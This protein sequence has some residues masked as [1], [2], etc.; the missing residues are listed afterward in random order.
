MIICFVSESKGFFSSVQIKWKWCAW[1]LTYIVSMQRRALQQ[2]NGHT[3]KKQV[4]KKNTR[5]LRA[6]LSRS[7][8]DLVE[9]MYV[10]VACV[11]VW[12][13][14]WQE[15]IKVCSGSSVS[16]ICPAVPQ[17]P[18]G[19]CQHPAARH[20]MHYEAKFI[21]LFLF[22]FNSASATCA[23]VNWQTCQWLISPGV[24]PP[25]L[26]LAL[27]SP[28]L[29]SVSSL[30]LIRG[31]GGNRSWGKKKNEKERRIVVKKCM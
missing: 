19:L 4:H 27:A 14:E 10:N 1:C 9:F 8:A 24:R 17:G 26:V 18:G 22:P 7:E 13:S 28:Y 15:V 20:M 2:K 31:N 25:H 30:S 3:Q 29:A 11:S 23:F 6:L 5:L 16:V 21:L 12:V